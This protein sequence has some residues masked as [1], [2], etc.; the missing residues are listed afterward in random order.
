MTWRCD[1]HPLNLIHTQVASSPLSPYL[2]TPHV[3]PWLTHL[4][5]HGLL[6]VGSVG[7]TP[8]PGDRTDGDAVDQKREVVPA[9]LEGVV[10]ERGCGVE[11]GLELQNAF[12]RGGNRD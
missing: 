8:H 3:S 4:D 1:Q 6:Y 5:L 7:H 12:T 11:P 2:P 10:V 9:P